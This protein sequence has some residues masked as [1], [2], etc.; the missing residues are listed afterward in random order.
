MKDSFAYQQLYDNL[1]AE[2]YHESEDHTSHLAPYIRWLQDKLNSQ[3]V[4]DIGCSA[5]GSLSLLES[6]NRTAI[7]VDVSQLA[8]YKVQLLGRSVQLASATS[9]PFPD[10]SFELVVSADVF[11]HLHPD[12]AQQAVNEAIRVASK[13][14]FMKIAEHEDV[15]KKWKEIAGHPLHLTTKPI[16]WWMDMFAHAGKFIRYE[17]YI[18]CFALEQCDG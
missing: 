9:L 14:I 7:G 16:R 3:S 12:D 11:E 15:G 1:R 4:L 2:G 6:G 18:L 17:Q 10:N 5:G 13:Y 8:V